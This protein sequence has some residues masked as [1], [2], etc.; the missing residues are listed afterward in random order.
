MPARFS[1]F[2][3]TA[4]ASDA[5]AVHDRILRE[6]GYL[7]GPYKFWLASPGFTDRMEPVEDFLRHR[8]IL[9]DRQVELI[10]L[11]IARHWKSRYV[12]SS[13]QPAA[14]RAGVEGHVVEAIRNGA[15]PSFERDEEAVCYALC[16][17]LLEEHDV[18]DALWAQAQTLLGER[19]INEIMGLLGLYTAVC[20]TMNA[21]RIPPKNGEPDALQ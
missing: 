13:H 17:A 12:W 4:L 2:D 10:V 3:P 14:L 15:T 8:V 18:D 1:A 5:Q 20:L 11:V 7:P 21:Y 9:N 16:K 6:R 19:A